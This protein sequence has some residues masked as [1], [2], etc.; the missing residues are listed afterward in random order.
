M[1]SNAL[2][3]KIMDID[4]QIR[5]ATIADK[6][7]EIERT[8]HRQGVTNVLTPD[9]SKKSLQRAIDS[10]NARSDLSEKIGKG[11]YVLAEYGK[12]KRITIPMGDDHLIY[13]TT[14]VSA[15]HA[16]IIDDTLKLL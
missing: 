16:K 3:D 14:D 6:H 11:R 9:E 1:D 10:W 7:G 4:P 12:I 8:G 2:Y 5:F 13:L 15:D